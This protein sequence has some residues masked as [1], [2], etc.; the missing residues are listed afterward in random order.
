MNHS[1][2]NS[3][4][5]IALTA[6]CLGGLIGCER[7]VADSTELTA[8]VSPEST[9]VSPEPAT[10]PTV[11]AT[12][13]DA[14]TTVDNLTSSNDVEVAAKD[15]SGEPNDD[16]QPDENAETPRNDVSNNGEEESPSASSDPPSMKVRPRS[17][18]RAGGL[19]DLTFDDVEFDIEK[20]ADFERSMLTDEI[21]ALDGKEIIIRGFILESYQLKNIKEFVLVRDNQECCFGP[22]AY[23]YHNMQVEMVGDARAEYSLRPVTIRGKFTIKP[24]IGPD[25]K[26]Y[27][28]YHIAATSFQK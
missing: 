25:G 13:D 24:W 11:D 28:V 5:V 4:V 21:E 3:R 7:P 27:S 18:V 23:I 9:A 19:L 20:D 12:V 16:S 1:F 6:A 26:C 17:R 22:G 2:S 8:V 10:T 15:K 14:V